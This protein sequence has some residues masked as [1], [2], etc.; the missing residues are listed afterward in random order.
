[1]GVEIEFE[2]SAPYTV[3]TSR[4]M[5]RY[6]FQPP[7]RLGGLP[8]A[9]GYTRQNGDLDIGKIDVLELRPGDRL[10][11]GTQGGGGLADSLPRPVERLVDD[12]SD[13]LVSRATAEA[14]DGVAVCPDGDAD[15]SATETLRARRLAGG[16]CPRARHRRSTGRAATVPAPRA[17]AADG[18]SSRAR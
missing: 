14:D 9:T 12:L 10:R 6:I 4:A 5:E 13:G 8:A 1:M 18:R 17:E 11:I 15:L 2:T 7:G 16:G 3:V